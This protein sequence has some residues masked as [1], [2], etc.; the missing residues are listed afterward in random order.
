MQFTPELQRTPAELKK[1]YYIWKQ[2]K[3]TPRTPKTTSNQEEKQSNNTQEIETS[4]IKRK[5]RTQKN[6]T[7][8]AIETTRTTKSN[9]QA[10]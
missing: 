3:R 7:P 2:S 8:V 5:E 6:T 1:Q 10:K 9:R 4:S